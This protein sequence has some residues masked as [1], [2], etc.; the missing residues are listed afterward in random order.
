MIV[1]LVLVKTM[2]QSWQNTFRFTLKAKNGFHSPIFPIKKKSHLKNGFQATDSKKWKCLVWC[3]PNVW[4]SKRMP[5]GCDWR[6]WA[7]PRSQFLIFNLSLPAFA[8][9]QSNFL[10]AGT[11]RF[12]FLETH[13]EPVPYCLLSHLGWAAS[14]QSGRWLPPNLRA[15][16]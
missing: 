8:W 2:G 16:H 7:I 14:P 12:R 15:L 1:S 10:V 11:S 4:I 13:P 9:C 5:A 6:S 3:L